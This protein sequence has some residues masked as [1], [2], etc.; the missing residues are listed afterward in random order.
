MACHINSLI[1][2]KL[3]KS[4]FIRKGRSSGHNPDQTSNP[5]QSATEV[6]DKSSTHKETFTLMHPAFQTNL[7]DN[8]TDCN[9]GDH[10]HKNVLESSRIL[11]GVND[12]N[13]DHNESDG[14]ESEE[15]D[16]TSNG[17]IDFSNNNKT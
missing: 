11:H 8:K 17:C 13:C 6:I 16:L 9:N 3:F 14:S 10:L 5:H 1:F 2:S 7:K 15:I 4:Y 12:A